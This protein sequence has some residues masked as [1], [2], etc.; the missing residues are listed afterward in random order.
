M[1]ALSGAA[2]IS[3]SAAAKVFASPRLA[4]ANLR[5][6]EPSGELCY[7]ESDLPHSLAESLRGKDSFSRPFVQSRSTSECG[8][9][10]EE[11][12]SLAGLASDFWESIR[13]PAGDVN[14]SVNA[15]RAHPLA[16]SRNAMRAPVSRLSAAHWPHALDNLQQA[17]AE[18][19]IIS[20]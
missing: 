12:R 18:V 7:G 5:L 17:S 15:S 10:R 11:A 3:A 13:S 4:T 1:N 8:A 19:S 9:G 20:S 6:S 16:I 2:P 14:S